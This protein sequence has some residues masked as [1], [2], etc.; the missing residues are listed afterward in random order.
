MTTQSPTMGERFAAQS[1]IEELLRHHAGT[2]KRNA[3][4]HFFGYSP[5]DADSVSWYLGAK[6][7]IEVGKILATLPPEWRVFHALPIGQKGS[8]IDHLVVG[9][10]GIVTINTKN[11]S[12]KA[13]WV[14]GQTFMVSGQKQPY[15]HSAES[16]ARS[17]TTL[18]RKRIPH[19]PAV[20]PSIVLVSPKSLTLK[21]RPER[22]KVVAAT[23]LRRWL[24]KLPAT[25][26]AADMTELIAIIDDPGTWPPQVFPPA[27]NAVS[28]FA[29]LAAE[30]RAAWMRRSL[31][32]VVAFVAVFGG[33]PLVGP[34]LITAVIGWLFSGPH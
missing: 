6:G 3:F 17:V 13:I 24:V 30:V 33:L 31:W 14:A 27:E 23:G 20:Q 8:D 26:S 1:V 32:K 12:N 4:G 10:G 11:H 7:E 34:P 5:L 19:L 9:P 18:L 22:V 2:P 29:A 21:K 25:L 28:R 15:L 16:E